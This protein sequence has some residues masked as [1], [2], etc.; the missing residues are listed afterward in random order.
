MQVLLP[1]LALLLSSNTHG[2]GEEFSGIAWR[3]ALINAR[4]LG[5]KA[6]V[7]YYIYHFLHTDGQC[8]RASIKTYSRISDMGGTCDD[9]SKQANLQVCSV[10]EYW[11]LVQ[12]AECSALCPQSAFCVTVTPA[13]KRLSATF[14]SGLASTMHQIRRHPL[15]FFN[16]HRTEPPKETISSGRH[17]SQHVENLCRRRS[18]ERSTAP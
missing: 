17:I 16:H 6:S 12:V 14:A 11:G 13:P 9:I 18:H 15:L 7:L 4:I 2:H 3:S 1:S 5:G 8:K 10:H